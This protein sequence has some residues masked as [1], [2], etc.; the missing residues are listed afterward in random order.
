MVLHEQHIWN[1]KLKVYS[2]S[3]P[4]FFLVL[5]HNAWNTNSSHALLDYQNIQPLVSAQVLEISLELTT[6]MLKVSCTEHSRNVIITIM[7]KKDLEFIYC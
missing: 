3:N 7:L 5:Q 2:D 4:D 1:M 6:D